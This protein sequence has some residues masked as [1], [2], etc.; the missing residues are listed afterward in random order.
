MPCLAEMSR[1][2]CLRQ[3]GLDWPVGGA[4]P[5]YYDFLLLCPESVGRSQQGGDKGDQPR[6]FQEVGLELS[7]AITTPVEPQASSFILLRQQRYHGAPAEPTYSQP[8]P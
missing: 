2:L 4:S 1:W 5:A 3:G 7:G 8:L 6:A